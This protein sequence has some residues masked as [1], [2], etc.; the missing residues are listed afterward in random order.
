MMNSRRISKFALMEIL[1][2]CSWQGDFRVTKSTSVIERIGGVL[3]ER[4]IC[5]QSGIP[6]LEEAD[7]R[8]VLHIRD[9]ILLNSR[10]NILVRTVDSDVLVILIGLFLSIPFL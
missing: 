7:N 5:F 3:S 1:E 4:I 6:S 9:S 10:T 2:T 8:L